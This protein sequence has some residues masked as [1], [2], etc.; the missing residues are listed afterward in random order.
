MK[1]TETQQEFDDTWNAIAATGDELA[2]KEIT[3]LILRAETAE[4][5]CAEMRDMLLNFSDN[6]SHA[7][8]GKD[9]KV[10][11]IRELLN[12]S[13]RLGTSYVSLNGDLVKGL[14]RVL[15]NRPMATK[16][17]EMAAYAV[18]IEHWETFCVQ[19]NDALAKLDAARKEAGL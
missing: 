6:I 9:G 2:A 16:L 15:L 17:P 13:P 10:T 11:T 12:E 18:S 3:K 14:E 5:A 7:L 8:V 4:K 19:I 1:L